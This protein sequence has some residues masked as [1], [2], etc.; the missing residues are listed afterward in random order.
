MTSW[1]IYWITR[2]ELLKFLFILPAIIL[3]AGSLIWVIATAAEEDR[4]EKRAIRY[5]FVSFAL[6]FI[7]G[8]IPGEQT[9]AAMLII[10][11]I[12]KSIQENKQLQQLPNNVLEL[13][14]DWINSLKP[15]EK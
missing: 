13:A 14:N 10:P 8:M 5:A 3:A 9:A 1:Q 11:R 6:F 2:L 15:K 7:G 12:S 4:F